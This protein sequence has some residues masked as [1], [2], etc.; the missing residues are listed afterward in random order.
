[1]VIVLKIII[2][3]F[4][5]NSKPMLTYKLIRYKI[6]NS[7]VY[8]LFIYSTFIFWVKYKNLFGKVV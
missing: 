6:S 3:A 1:M 2:F 7:F 5:P 4:K 8:F